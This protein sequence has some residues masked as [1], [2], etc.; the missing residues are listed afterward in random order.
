VIPAPLDAREVK[1]HCDFLAIAGRYTRLRRSGRQY[2][3]L[4]PFHSERHPS[5]YVESKRKIFHCFGCGAG[6]DVFAF[7]MRA[8]SCDFPRALAIADSFPSGVAAVSEGRRPERF[9]GGVGAKPLGPPKAGHQH[10]PEVQ[11]KRF[12]AV[13]RA[14]RT[15]SAALATA[16]ELE[17]GSLLLVINRITV[18]E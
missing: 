11:R 17:H 16:C 9:D 8:E 10:S 15:A 12:R 5:F 18:H 1:A 13:E 6:G 3:G 2:A 7:I 14:N 4:C